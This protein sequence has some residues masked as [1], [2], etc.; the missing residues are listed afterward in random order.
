MHG[1]RTWP[2]RRL[3]VAAA[4][5]WALTG[6]AHGLGG[7]QE[8]LNGPPREWA[9]VAAQMRAVG[10]SMGPL[11]TDVYDVYRTF[12]WLFTV[13]LFASAGSLLH[14]VRWTSEPCGRR[15]L[16]LWH[17]A[18]ATAMN[19]VCLVF[20]TPPPV[21]FGLAIAVLCLESYRRQRAAALIS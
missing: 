16:A 4:A 1:E 17:A 21:P 13:F 6:L 12:S 15:R 14:A 3:L 10:F 20:M 19:A 11:R 8:L 9:T 2:G 18:F 7:L 5:L